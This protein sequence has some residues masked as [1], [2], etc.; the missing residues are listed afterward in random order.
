[1]TMYDILKMELGYNVDVSQVN[2]ILLDSEVKSHCESYVID[3]DEERDFCNISATYADDAVKEYP[4]LLGG[5]FN[6]Q[7]YKWRNNEI[8]QWIL[9]V[10]E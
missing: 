4:F 3:E 8:E 1:M 6:W 5:Q 7:F 9:D 2:P 10:I